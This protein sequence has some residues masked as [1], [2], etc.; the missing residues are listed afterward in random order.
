M[1]GE[2]PGA[3]RGAVLDGLRE[4]PPSPTAISEGQSYDSHVSTLPSW[5]PGPEG[6]NPETDMFWQTRGAG[7][8]R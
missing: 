6:A 7:L 4:M 2:N 5:G 8:E 3:G 1:R